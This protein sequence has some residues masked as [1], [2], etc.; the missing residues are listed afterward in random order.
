MTAITDLIS[1]DNESVNET[2]YNKKQIN[3]FVMNELKEFAVYD[4]SRSI[5]S[6]VDGLKTSQRKVIYATFTLKKDT[7]IK[8][9]ALGAKSS[10]L[11]HYK[12][13][14]ASIIGTVIKLAQDYA[15]S[16]NYPILLKDG[17][18]GT[19]QNNQ[20][21]SPRYIHVS[22]SDN[23]DNMFDENDREIVNYLKFDGDS[24]E[25]EY[26]LTKL[27]LIA[28]NGTTGIGNG[29]STKILQ[30]NTQ[31][32]AKYISQIINK[33]ELDEAL[34]YPAFNG[35]N[36]QV[37]ALTKSSFLIKGRFERLDKSTIII[38][39]L[40]PSSSFQYENY[41]EKVL[42]P[43]KIDTK[44]GVTDFENESKDGTWNII[45]KHDRFFGRK[46]DDEIEKI[47]KLTEKVTENITVWGYDNKFKVFDDI[48]QLIE[49]WTVE[50]A[51][52]HK[53]RKDHVL[54]KMSIKNAYQ[55][56][57]LKLIEYWL[58]NPEIAK[59]KKDDL[60]KTLQNVADDNDHISRFLDQNIMSLTK[61]RV[62]KLKKDISEIIK[63][64]KALEKK[65]INTLFLE[66]LK[67]F[68]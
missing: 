19:A 49:Y 21:S 67:Q 47:L 2:I 13:G 44:S 6:V 18:F 37:E 43:L 35:F 3:D 55:E 16:N 65:S 56:N 28:I 8:T 53:V 34:L 30:R 29:Y 20:S 45:I 33:E 58:E 27:P 14:E 11:T 66:D 26:Y 64:R 41:K 22:R 42:I 57:L 54:E 7:P 63:E 1:E 40:P 36:G 38:R 62:E 9:S 31:N 59:L 51:K 12:H 52:W 60:I 10:D 15:G 25:P 61:E 50:R 68:I 17:Q 5:P 32:V 4:N 48:Y 23:L 46:T 39:D 24:I